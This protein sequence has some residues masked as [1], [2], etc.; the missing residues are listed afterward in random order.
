[1]I[2][3]KNLKMMELTSLNDLT[4]T[5]NTVFIVKKDISYVISGVIEPL[6]SNDEQKISNSN[7]SVITPVIQIL[8]KTLTP[9]LKA[10]YFMTKLLYAG[11]PCIRHTEFGRKEIS[12]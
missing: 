4:R 11:L 8:Q 10:L 7:Q 9:T 6:K 3:P 12:Y 1:M 5:P 2:V